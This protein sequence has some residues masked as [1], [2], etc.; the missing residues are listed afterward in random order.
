AQV[1]GV[2]TLIVAMGV[3]AMSIWVSPWGALQTERLLAEQRARSEFTMLRAGHFQP[4][5]N[6][7][8]VTYVEELTENRTRLNTLFYAESGS[9]SGAPAIAVAE[10]GTQQV[11]PEYQ[12]RYLQLYNGVRYQ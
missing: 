3:G 6:G 2:S 10:Y 7:R 5:N 11:H 8:Q 12:E 1:T 9:D 4:I